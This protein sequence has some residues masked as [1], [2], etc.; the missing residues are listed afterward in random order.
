[1]EKKNTT[2]S[3]HFPKS[4]KN[5]G[6]REKNDALIIQLHDHSLPW[7]GTGISIKVAG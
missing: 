1:M 3:E 4:Q 6:K 2:L 5:R 7:I